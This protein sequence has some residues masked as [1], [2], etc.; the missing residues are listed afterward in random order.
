MTKRKEK[1]ARKIPSPVVRRLAKY[2]TYVND[3][4]FRG[5]KWITSKDLAAD[6]GLTNATVRRDIF[7]LNFSGHTNRGYSIEN[8]ERVLTRVLGLHKE[9]DIVIVGAGNLGRALAMHGD[10]A[11]MGFRI[12]GIFDSDK[13]LKRK[14]VS[15]L[16]IQSM[17]ALS[18][19][20]KKYAVSIG[21]IAVPS[22][23][24]QLVANQLVKAGVRGVLN[25]ACANLKLPKSV[26]VVEARIAAGLSELCCCVQIA[27]GRESAA[28]A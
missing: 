17:N 10:L 1:A 11:R 4:A 22:T 21:I 26:H 5:L 13:K 15:G 19:V 12:R 14:K 27:A 9:C 7:Y 18:A 8:L 28:L 3:V 6:L 16:V 25:L 24:A 23:A 2:R 20:V